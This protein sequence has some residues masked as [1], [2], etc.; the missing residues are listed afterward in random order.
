MA[1]KTSGRAR[2]QAVLASNLFLG[3]LVGTAAFVVYL[4]T[5]LPDVG[6]PEDSPK[7]QYLGAVL[8]TAHAPGYPL[9][10]LLSH[11]FS[12]IPLGT[13]AYRANL[14]SAMFGAV[15]VAMAVLVA[16]ASGASRA[17][18]ALGALAMAF[19]AA[20]WHFSVLAEVYSLTAALLLAIVYW[21]VRWRQSGRDAHLFAAAGFFALAI[22]NHL[23]IVAAA[24]AIA[25]VSAGD[26]RA[27]RAAFARAAARRVDRRERVPS[28]RLH[29][30]SHA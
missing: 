8:G 13:I 23:S 15:A 17:A 4:R 14:M 3:I 1:V 21:L 11:V 19:G 6:G 30:D 25:L 7:F 28:I 10:T 5:L 26:R 9:H 29:P 12:Y 20:F 18:A 2:F 24:P 22:G 16:R 27:P